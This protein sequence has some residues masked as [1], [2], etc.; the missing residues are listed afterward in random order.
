MSA[1]SANSPKW[2]SLSVRD[3]TEKAFDRLRW[4]WGKLHE[5]FITDDELVSA[6]LKGVK[7]KDL[8]APDKK[9]MGGK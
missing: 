5:A 7:A 2:A 4:D 9:D 3:T 1:T 6:L 8:P